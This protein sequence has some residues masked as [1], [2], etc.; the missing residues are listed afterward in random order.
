MLYL[1]VLFSNVGFAQQKTF[2]AADLIQLEVPASPVISPDAKQ[3]AFTIRKPDLQASQWIMQIYVVSVAKKSVRQMTKSASDCSSPSWSPD[4]KWL[5]FLSKRESS[6]EKVRNDS[7]IQRLFALPMEGGEA[8]TLTNLSSDIEEY[9]WSPDG[10]KIAILAEEEISPEKRAETEKKIK[11]KMDWTSSLDPKPGK[12]LWMLNV[13]LKTAKKIKTL[14]PGAVNLAWSPDSKKIVYQTDY[15]GEYNDEQKFDIWTID[16]DG[17]Q[18]QLTTMAGPEIYPRFS[19]DGKWIAF[20][21]QTVPDIEFAKTELTIMDQTG[22]NVRNLTKDFPWSVKQFGWTANGKEIIARIGERTYSTI[23]DIEVSNGKIEKLVEGQNVFGDVSVAKDGT[24]TTTNETSSTLKEVVLLK[25]G[26]PQTLTQYSKQLD[27]YQLRKQEVVTV[28]S[29]DGKFDIEAIL[30][31]PADYREGRKY[32]LMLAYH[33]GP[34]DNYENTFSQKYPVQLLVQEGTMVVMPN[35]RGS[36]GYTDEFG[37]SIRYDLGGGDYRDAMDIVDYLIAEGMVDTTKMGVMGGSYGGYLT[38]W[39]ITQTPRFKAAISM[40]T[41]FSLFTDWGNSWQPAF[42]HMYL[43]YN[44]WDRPI[45]MNSRW[46]KQAP[47]TYVKNITTPTLILQGT[48]DKYTNISNSREM[49][50]ALKELGKTVEFVIYPRAEH[51]LRTEPNQYINVMERT[52][53]WFKK[54]ALGR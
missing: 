51:G 42:E 41:M 48:E 9:T 46:V 18:T 54:Y 21:T 32:P 20:I 24:I 10:T 15:T 19:P 31:K 22:K 37:Q 33:G 53:G 47:Q 7:G 2:T 25:K 5:T 26:K 39:T 35:V 50:Q 4:G 36:S 12:D 40:Y 3:V 17:I 6:T 43:G 49:Y 44:Y 28:K 13:D 30:I 29:R 16:L 34:Y 27:T 11:I 1:I 45:D 38:N 52:V 14:D 23:Y 8:V